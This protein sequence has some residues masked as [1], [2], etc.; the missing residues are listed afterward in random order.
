MKD[1]T[2]REIEKAKA[3]KDT[4]RKAVAEDPLHDPADNHENATLEEVDRALEV[5]E[6]HH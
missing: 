6:S 4:R 2:E 5:S 1:S 3:C